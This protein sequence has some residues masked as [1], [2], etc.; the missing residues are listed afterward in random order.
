MKRIQF[1]DRKGRP[2]DFKKLIHRNLKLV[3]VVLLVLIFATQNILSYA[4]EI[5]KAKQN[6]TAL[7]RKKEE[8]ESKI[9]E[10]EK[11]KDSFFEDLKNEIEKG[12]H[13]PFN[14]D[15]RD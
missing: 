9:K 6:K 15:F 8:T 14:E 7:E 2:V 3:P 11:E 4:G 1:T 12:D 13:S 10:L 5:D